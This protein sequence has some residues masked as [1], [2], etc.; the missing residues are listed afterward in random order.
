MAISQSVML[1]KPF[2]CTL[3]CWKVKIKQTDAIIPSVRIDVDV[4]VIPFN[5][6]L[7]HFTVWMGFQGSSNLA[8]QKITEIVGISSLHRGSILNLQER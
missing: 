7:H 5:W 6:F 3:I 2:F 8:E 1:W 4:D